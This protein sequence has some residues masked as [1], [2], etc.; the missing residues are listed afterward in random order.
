MLKPKHF[1]HCS[2]REYYAISGVH[3]LSSGEAEAHL[4]T[5]FITGIQYIYTA[6]AFEMSKPK[7]IIDYYH[8]DTIS[9]TTPEPAPH[10]IRSYHTTRPGD[11]KWEVICEHSICVQY[12][13]VGLLR[14]LHT[15]GNTSVRKAIIEF[16]KTH[17]YI[18]VDKLEFDDATWLM[19][20]LLGAQD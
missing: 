4:D 9:P 5:E 8:L 19:A 18:E 15:T 16:I 20:N 1:Q 14:K 7:I 17:K 10:H 12:P 3:M 11:K 13:E 6:S 2:V